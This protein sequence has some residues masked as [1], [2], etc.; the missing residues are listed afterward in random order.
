MYKE[1]KKGVWSAEEKADI[2]KETGW[3]DEVIDAIGS[4]A[5]YEIYKKAELVEVKIGDKVCLV[6][7]DIDWNQK[8]E[9][10]RTNK[11]LAEQGLAPLDKNGK[12]IELHHIGQKQDSPLAEL[13]KEEHLSNGND[14]VLHDKS[15]SSEIDRSAFA[16]E[17]AEHWEERAKKEEQEKWVV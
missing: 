2:K 8:D 6:K 10:G 13:T 3:S 14:T 17:R 9:L 11:E 7:P 15:K 5:E 1:K 12:P 4:M 16:R